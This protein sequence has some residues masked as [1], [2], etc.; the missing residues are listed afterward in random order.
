M[1]DEDKTNKII[2]VVLALIITIAAITLI[3]VNLAEDTD[4]ETDQDQ[5][6]ETNNETD[7]EIIF[8]LS[9]GDEIKEYS[10]SML[11]EIEAYESYGGLIKL[12]WLPDIVLEG[13]YNYTG[14]K[15]TTLLD[16]FTPARV[17]LRTP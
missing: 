6:D 10:L 13:P 3:Y 17:A 7:E 1:L 14:I 16:E 12:G 9:Y 4:E 8:T 5:Q 11:E 2:T 15:I